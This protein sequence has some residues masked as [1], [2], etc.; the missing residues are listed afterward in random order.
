MDVV[1]YRWIIYSDIG[2]LSLQKKDDW[3]KMI[4]L[5]SVVHFHSLNTGF[6]DSHYWVGQVDR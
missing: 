1:C 4:K 3:S 5:G 6:N 2:K